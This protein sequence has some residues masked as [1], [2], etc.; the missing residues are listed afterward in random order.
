M[1]AE[2]Y[3]EIDDLAEQALEE[4]KRQEEALN[5]SFSEDSEEREIQEER[6]L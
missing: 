2:E 3:I 5:N 4:E 6:R 1:L